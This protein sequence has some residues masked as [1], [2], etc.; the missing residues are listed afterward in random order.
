MYKLNPVD[1]SDPWLERACFFQ[2]LNLNCDILDLEVC[3]QAHLVPLHPGNAKT[4]GNA[5]AATAA[6]MDAAKTPGGGATTPG[7]GLRAGRV[8]S[9]RVN[10]AVA[11]LHKG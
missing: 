3:L 9:E 8:L 7:A 1:P 6:A 10:A 4:P 5:A 11:G 2:I